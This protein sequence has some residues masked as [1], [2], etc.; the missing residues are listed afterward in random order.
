MDHADFPTLLQFFKA[1]ANDSRLRLLG[2]VA[3][4]EHN[5]QELAK[6][7]KLSEPTASHHLAILKRLGLVSLRPDGNTH[8]YALD[9]DALTQLARSVL[10]REQVAALAPAGNAASETSP[11][12]RNYV[13]PNGEITQIPASRK[14]RRIILS[15]LVQKFEIDKTYSESEVNM[16]IQRHH[17][18]CATLR[19]E[20]IGY[21]M[22]IRNQGAYRR[23]PEAEWQ[24]E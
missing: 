19:R 12:L 4:R 2:L 3:Q 23:L 20:L 21:K 11:V 7:L 13:S 22:M 18:D 17:Q 6:R 8:W 16:M 14:K 24:D 1:L 15:W 5:V 9:P 10:N